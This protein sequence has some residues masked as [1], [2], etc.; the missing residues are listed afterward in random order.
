MIA[1]YAPFSVLLTRGCPS[2]YAIHS[3]VNLRLFIPASGAHTRCEGCEE[4]YSQR[5]QTL[6]HRTKKE[7]QAYQLT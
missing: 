4:H 1:M 2:G 5:S 3:P 6:R 7:T